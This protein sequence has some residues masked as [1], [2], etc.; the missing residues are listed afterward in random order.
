MSPPTA[1]STA[2][3]PVPFA[4]PDLGAAE[5]AEVVASLDSGWFS[6]GPRVR[7]FV[8]AFAAYTGAPFAIAVNSCT[9]ALHL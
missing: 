9:A 2:A 3:R 5:I 6:S 1:A 4:P 7:A 8:A